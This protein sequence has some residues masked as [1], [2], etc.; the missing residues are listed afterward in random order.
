VPRSQAGH[1]G[2]LDYEAATS[3]KVFDEAR[4][5]SERAAVERSRL[6][7]VWSPALPL[8]TTFFPAFAGWRRERIAGSPIIAVDLLTPRADESSAA[9]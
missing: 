5:L 3:P 6:W 1:P 8:E 9:R 7:L 4:V 2:W